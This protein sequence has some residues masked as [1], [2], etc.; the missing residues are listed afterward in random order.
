[1]IIVLLYRRKEN[2]T[3]T[4]VPMKDNEAYATASASYH[5]KIQ[6]NEAYGTIVL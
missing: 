3:V 1:M 6:P 2:S 5:M 4:A